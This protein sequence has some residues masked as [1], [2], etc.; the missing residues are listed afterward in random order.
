MKLLRP[1]HRQRT[2]RR[3][4][5]LVLN[6]DD[7]AAHFGVARKDLQNH[8]DAKQIPYHLDSR[9]EIWASIEP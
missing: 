8:L 1:L 6:G 5:A 9:G 2:R 7:L 4:R 3:S